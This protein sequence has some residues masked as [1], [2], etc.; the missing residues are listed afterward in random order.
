MLSPSLLCY[1]LLHAAD[2]YIKICCTKCHSK[3]IRVACEWLAGAHRNRVRVKVFRQCTLCA[4]LCAALYSI[5]YTMHKCM[6][7]TPNHPHHAPNRSRRSRASL[8]VVLRDCAPKPELI[9]SAAF[10][11][12]LPLLLMHTLT[13]ASGPE[14]VDLRVEANERVWRFN[15]RAPAV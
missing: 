2:V 7:D 12:L 3:T 10:R 13:G 6:H 4:A 15:R 8:K 1:P 14:S 11:L 5:W 9:A